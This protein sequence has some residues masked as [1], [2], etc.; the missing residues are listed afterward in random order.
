[1]DQSA[2]I[3]SWVGSERL[4]KARAWADRQKSAACNNPGRG[5]ATLLP[6]KVHFSLH[7]CLKLA[8]YPPRK[9]GQVAR[10]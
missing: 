7:T 2:V 6:F 5:I 10:G 9:R 3:P 8:I 4:L 1:M